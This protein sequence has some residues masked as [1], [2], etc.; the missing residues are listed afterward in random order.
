MFDSME[1]RVSRLEMV[2]EA[3]RLMGLYSYYMTQKQFQKIPALFAQQTQQ[4][5]AEMLW[6][7]YEG[8]A[9]LDRLYCGLFPAL[10]DSGEYQVIASLQALEVPIITA[11]RDGKTAKGVWVSPGYA[12]VS[13]ENGRQTGYWSWQKYG[14]DFLRVGQELKIW[15]L[16][17]Y[18]LFENAYGTTEVLPSGT[19]A[20]GRNIPP[21][22]SPDRPPTTRFD[23]SD[24]SIYPYAPAVPKPYTVFDQDYAY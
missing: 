16:H 8:K 1:E 10:E 5:Y 9:G 3:K 15:H 11:A 22:F 18:G 20:Y 17:V 13:E 19:V 23:L 4:T 12:T 14:C 24:V 21:E 7:V 6:G 2:A